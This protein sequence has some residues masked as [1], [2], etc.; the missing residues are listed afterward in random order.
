MI[1]E[2]TLRLAQETV[3]RLQGK[4]WFIRCVESCTAGAITAAIGT[5]SGASNVLDRSWITYSNQAKHEE[6]GVPLKTLETFGAVSKEVV[7][8]MAEGAV[9][10]CEDNTASIS[11]SGIAGPTGGSP[12]KPVGTVWIGVKLPHRPVQ[13]HLFQFDGSRAEVQA[14]SVHQALKLLSLSISDT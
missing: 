11:I 2:D 1:A 12:D 14:Q 10:N 5:V 13:T 8:A 9:T 4:H 6:V 3:S 7:A